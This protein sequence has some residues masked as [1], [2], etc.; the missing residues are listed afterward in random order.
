MKTYQSMV[1][2][3]G[4]NNTQLDELFLLAAGIET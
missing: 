2:M 1:E 4:L 3:L